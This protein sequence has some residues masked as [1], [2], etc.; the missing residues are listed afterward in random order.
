MK[1]D[2]GSP[3][4]ITEEMLEGLS[5]TAL[6]NLKEQSGGN[7]YQIITQN[8][9][10][11]AVMG[12]REIR[13]S[14]NNSHLNNVTIQ[15]DTLEELNISEEDLMSLEQDIRKETL[16]EVAEEQNLM[17]FE[18][19]KKSLAQ[20]DKEQAKKYLGWIT[21]SIGNVAAAITIGNAL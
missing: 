15:S 2:T 16:D 17:F 9:Q 21:K 19:L 14:F 1:I 6:T 12:K 18:E 20:H 7:V 4:T 13:G 11:D 3:L 10:G 8:I 5:Y